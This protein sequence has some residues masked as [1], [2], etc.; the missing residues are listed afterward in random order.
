MHSRIILSLVAFS[1]VL[2]GWLKPAPVQ[3][4]A[5]A[6]YQQLPMMFEANAGQAHSSI[7]YIAR[8]HGYQVF[9]TE[10]DATL[11]L[12]GK[13]ENTTA[14]LQLKLNAKALTPVATN[15]LRTRSN[16]F[17]GHDPSAWLTD[18]RNYA[19]VEYREI[20]PGVAVAFYGTQRALE[21]DFILAPGTD[22]ADISLTLAGADR[23]ESLPN[24]DLRLLVNGAELIQRAPIAYQTIRNTR[25]AVASRYVLQGGN[26][27]GFEVEAYDASQSLV[28]DPIID[29]SSFF[30]GIGSDE[31]LAIA[32]DSVG[33][34]Y[35]TGTTYS[36]NFNTVLPLQ[37]V[38]RGGKFDAFVAKLNA[39]GTEIVYSTYLGG[40]GED[41]G[42]GI[43]VDATGN[44][45]IAGITNSAD[46]NTR[47]PLQ[48]NI[49]GQA[50]DAFVAKLNPTGTALIYSSY[51]GGSGIDQAFAIAVDTGG[52]A[53]L[54]GSTA[55]PDFPTLGPF[56]TNN[57]GGADAFI[58]KVNA[59]GT[60]LVYSS[61]FGGTNLDEAYAVA[62]DNTGNAYLAGNTSSTDLT[63]VSAL[64]NS[65]RGGFDG[66]VAK[67]NVNGSRVLY[68]TYLGG[69]A[70][71]TVYTLKTDAAGI[72]YVA[73]NTF[74][75]DFPTVNALQTI[76][77]GESDAFIARISESGATLLS[78]TYYGGENADFA[79][80]LGLDANDQIYVAGRTASADLTTV[81]PL[82]VNNRGNED[83]F[84]LKL[85]NA[86]SQLLYAT[87]LGGAREDF[88]FGIAVDSTGNAYV[89]GD[90]RSTDFNTRNPL[91][92]ANRGGLDAFVTKLNPNGSQLIYS[93]YLGGAGEDLGLGIALDTAGNAYITGYT[94]SNDYMTRNPLQATN[95]G[96][97]EV[98]VTKILADNNDVAFNT[99]FGG[100]GSDT[101]YGIAVDGGGN[102]Y[103]AG[104]TTSTNLPTRNPLQATNGGGLDAFVAKFNA[105]GSTLVFAT[106]LGGNFGD[107]A[108]GIAVDVAGNAYIAGSSFSDNFPTRNAVQGNQRGQGDA[109]VAKLDGQ[110]SQLLYSTYLGGAA[111]DGASRIAIDPSGNAYVVGTTFSSD[112]N[113]RNPLQATNRG[114]Q[115]AFA[116][117]LNPDGSQLLYST[118][119]GGRRNDLAEA[120]AVDQSGNAYI[121]GSTNSVDFPT[122]NPLQAANG[123]GGDFDAFVTKLNPQ[124][125][126]II[127]STYLGGG[128][129]D[130]ASGVALDAQGSTFVTG[131][132][133]SLNFPRLSALQNDNRGGNDAFLTRLS[134]AGNTLFYSTY[135]GGSGEDNGGAIAVDARGTA[136]L[137]G[138][139]ASPD[140]N[141]QFPLFAYG[142]GTDIFVARI[143]PDVALTLAPATLDLQPGTTGTL[144]LTLN[145]PQANAVTLTLSSSNSTAVAL[146]ATVTVPANTSSVALTVSALATGVA[147]ITATLPANL[148]GAM[149][150]STVNVATVSAGGL[151]ADVAPRPNGN[152]SLSIAD[153]VQVGRFAA[154]FD[155]VAA[156][157]EFQRADC[158][159]RDTRGNGAIS[160]SDWVQAGRYAAG[161][162]P[163]LPAGGPTSQSAA[164]SGQWS[165]VSG[166]EAAQPTRALR[167]VSTALARGV[168]GSVVIEI[169][170]Q[171]NE[172]G[173][174]FSL[175]YD[176]AQLNFVNAALAPEAGAPAFNINA[177]Q[178]GNGRLGI[179]LAYA[180]GQS[181]AAGKRKLFT[182]NFNVAANASANTTTINFS[183]QPVARE[184]VNPNA[185]TLTAEF[186]AGTI[187]LMRA[188]ASVSAASYAANALAPDSIV[189]GFG[190]GLATATQTATTIPLP[191][192]L[193]GTSIKV[194]DA[195]GVERAAPLFFVSPNQVNYLMPVNTAAGAATVTLTS[196][197]NILS[198]GVVNLAASAPG[199]FT[200]NASGQGVPSALALRVKANGVLSYESLMQF[201]A[202][203]NQFVPAPIDLGPESDQV[204]LLLFGTGFRG[205]SAL[206]AVTARLANINSEVLFAGPQGDLV[207]LDQINVR[208]PRSLI[209]RGEVAVELVADNREVNAV[210]VA[211]K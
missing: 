21:Y 53:Y 171:G 52:N 141:V 89:T 137:T 189:A 153:W 109:F 155:N 140:F 151:E 2:G 130:T 204:F 96:G 112:F 34:A 76:N 209:G 83:A 106:Y 200:A 87:Y 185:Q 168:Q 86:A 9:L 166:Q 108:R 147:T 44:A 67:V 25:R 61:Y 142:G 120:V 148:G 172:N 58:A 115:D 46:F 100:N 101:G 138:A 125:A 94:S 30:G 82:Q 7:K 110:G 206:S 26:R 170:A 71:D 129:I 17:I 18:I 85:N 118:Y 92:A 195:L 79:R 102:A 103:V 180:A 124:G 93:T 88:A 154:G 113:T 111:S 43:A 193:A 116:A 74:S 131:S 184:V 114:Q 81:S 77:R 33:N 158:A 207:G 47:N 84:V 197:D 143:L 70:V 42:Q 91:Q 90:T 35:V 69:S 55:S 145:P 107:E 187:T 80:G 174:G 135:L 194:R 159:P 190:T 60:A 160:I 139:T 11:R 68:A 149:A 173:I 132:T 38:N 62:V 210:R 122:A 176:A 144:T 6:S 57:R 22:P 36:N 59:A 165:I 164:V 162:D 41:S 19:R 150:S 24:G 14:Q 10:A 98:F 31:G 186:S 72:A 5:A 146:P 202:G 66:F 169:D 199:L 23:I 95:R 126:Q 123:G 63:T 201:D 97:L 65:N 28:I 39:A 20:R 203:R 50:N 27:I 4:T 198:L 152:G 16:Y 205:R 12:F 105:T 133:N 56:Q 78:S 161:L 64:Q 183:D 175:N 163:E 177:T 178:A 40:S 3:V 157:G 13:D 191:T 181:I 104:A 8:G 48:A 121:A 1:L 188:L 156:G 73:G 128:L 179:A 37:T 196:G 127:Y 208:I 49:N 167:I 15:E 99:Y 29:Y 134:P 117:K 182:L 51:L 136:Y 119:L 32:L 211:I 75:T 45:Y 54:T 192:T